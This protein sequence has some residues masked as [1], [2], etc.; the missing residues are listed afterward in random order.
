MKRPTL[1]G[2]LTRVQILAVALTCSLMAAGVITAGGLL[3]R[4]DQDRTL[5]AVA[6]SLCHVVALERLETLDGVSAAQE[7]LGEHSLKGYWL[8]YL[9]AD[10]TV[11]VAQ[12]SLPGW[13]PAGEGRPGPDGCRSPILSS[14]G[15][16]AE[17]GAVYRACDHACAPDEVVRVVTLDVLVRPEVRL[18]AVGLLAALPLAL[19]GGAAAGVLLFRRRLHPLRD[20]RRAARRL[21]T[22]P[23]RRLGV[24]TRPAELAGLEEAFDGLLERL[25][26]ALDREKRFTQEASHELRTPLAILRGR[27][28][29]LRSQLESQPALWEEADT[30]VAD[31]DALDRLVEALLLL[32]LSESTELPAAAVNLCDLAREAAHLEILT[33]DPGTRPLEVDAPD[34]IL[35]RGSE[36]LLQRALGNLIENSR[37]F[38][39]K[40]A[41]I[42]VRALE[43]DGSGV[44]SVQDSGPGIPVELRPVVFERFVR[45]AADRH[46]VPG[47]GLGLA[48]VRAIMVRHGGDVS[49]GPGALGGEEVRLRLP[50]L[51]REVAS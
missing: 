6:A 44:L 18:A 2:Q 10:G 24:G 9:K 38:A 23:G 25:G 47:M 29:H 21:R 14:D 22:R 20:L 17:S 28:E 8:E 4:L 37:K 13:A 30:A 32:A 1:V 45:G 7:G 41:R 34:E 26:D 27:L 40:S 50:L 43:Q 39:G 35:V 36:E 19:L 46:H 31:L 3:L 49:T 42:R 5:G 15:Q 16:G 11:L 12:G 33:A 51:S 48:V